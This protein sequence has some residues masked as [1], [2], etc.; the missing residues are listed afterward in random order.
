MREQ[1]AIHTLHC[2]IMR[3]GLEG[4]AVGTLSA[5]WPLC[6]VYEVEDTLEATRKCYDERNHPP[7]HLFKDRFADSCFD[8]RT[9]KEIKKWVDKDWEGGA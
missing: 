6:S 5:P 4:E 3:T 8:V 9:Y 1:F 7:A 2:E